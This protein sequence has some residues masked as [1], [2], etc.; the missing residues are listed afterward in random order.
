MGRVAEA[1][2]PQVSRDAARV[3]DYLA[4]ARRHGLPFPSSRD[5]RRALGMTR[6]AYARAINEARAVTARSGEGQRA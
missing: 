3:L 5:A 4:A 6:R 1:G 2:C